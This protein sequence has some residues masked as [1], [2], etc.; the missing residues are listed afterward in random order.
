MVY[1]CRCGKRKIDRWRV[2]TV[3]VYVHVDNHSNV[4]RAQDYEA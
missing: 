4:A 1:E 2:K 3:V